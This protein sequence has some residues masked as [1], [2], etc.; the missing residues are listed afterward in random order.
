ML[1]L[2]VDGVSIDKELDE[3]GQE[4]K[5]A[6]SRIPDRLDEFFDYE[7]TN[8]SEHGFHRIFFTYFRPAAK[9][10]KTAKATRARASGQ[11]ISSPM[12]LR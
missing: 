5:D 3:R 1:D 12:P 8:P 7:V 11:R 9:R 4:K 6:Q 10:K 2:K